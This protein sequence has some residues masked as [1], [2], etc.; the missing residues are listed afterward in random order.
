MLQDD[1]MMIAEFFTYD[2][3]GDAVFAFV[4]MDYLF[5]YTLK[6][7]KYVTLNKHL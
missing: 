5:V 6:V 7:I 3:T 2:L 1:V 4:R